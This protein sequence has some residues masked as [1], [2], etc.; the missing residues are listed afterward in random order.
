MAAE[1]FGSATL[2][3]V[4]WL[5]LTLGGLGAAWAAW[6][7]GWRG[8]LGLALGAVLSWINFRWLKGSV[9]PSDRLPRSSR[10][11]RRTHPCRRALT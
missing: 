10:Q 7:W 8:G 5:T 11:E 9:Q 4:E 3:R 6:R 2:R 1:A